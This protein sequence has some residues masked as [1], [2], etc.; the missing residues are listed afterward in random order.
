[1]VMGTTKPESLSEQFD[2]LYMTFKI[3]VKTVWTV[4]PY[5]K[6]IHITCIVYVSI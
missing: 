3:A 2:I 1:M 6:C 4:R 5:V